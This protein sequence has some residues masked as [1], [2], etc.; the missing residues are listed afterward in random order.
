ME[1]RW[2]AWA[3]AIR[4][5][6]LPA[7]I[8]PVIAGVAVAAAEGV[9]ASGPAFA[10]LVGA[11]CIQIGTNLANDYY[12]AERGVDTDDRKGFTRVTQAGLLSPDSVKRGMYASFLAA[13]VIGLYLIAVGGMPILVIGVLSLIAGITYAGGPF[14]F[15]SYGLGDLFVFIFFGIIAVTGTY[16]VQAVSLVADPFPLWIPPETISLAALIVSVAMGALTTAILVVNNLRDIETDAAA[17]KRTLAVYIGER[18]SRIEFI[19]L[20]FIAYAV[21]VALATLGWSLLVLLPLLSIPFAIYVARIVL[22]H[23]SGERLNLALERT[24]QL[25]MVYVVLLAIGVLG[26]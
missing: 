19:A 21:P 26:G 11:L 2:R 18:N 7:G 13:M 24:G 8:A 16:Y 6:T 3:I 22:E 23:S 1:N 25:L 9:F 5:Q 10:A 15:G 17:G 14:P 20:L 4:P 12:D